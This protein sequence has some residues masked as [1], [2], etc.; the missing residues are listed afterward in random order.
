MKTILAFIICTAAF[1]YFLYHSIKFVANYHEQFKKFLEK[2]HPTIT[3]RHRR[4]YASLHKDF[5]SYV[6]GYYF[7]TAI[8]GYGTVYLFIKILSRF[9]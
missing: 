8:A 7:C 4:G 5:R 9:I 1:G 6:L 3:E 2:Y